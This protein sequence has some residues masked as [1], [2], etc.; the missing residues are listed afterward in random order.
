MDR[1]ALLLNARNLLSSVTPLAA[2]CGRLC[3]HACCAG[4]LNDETGMLLFPGEE[5]FYAQAPW[6]RIVP[7][8]YTLGASPAL[9]L[10]CDG[11]CPRDERPLSCRLFPLFCKVRGEGF[12]VCLDTRAHALCPL[13][14]YGLKGLSQAF[15]QAAESSYALPW[16]ED[17]LRAYLCALSS[18][19]SL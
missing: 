13:Y 12:T 9:L 6:A 17:N 16:Q 8:H 15:V 18:A 2:D 5:A 14:R 10:T 3:G 7:L 19:C 4:S 1:T 11:R